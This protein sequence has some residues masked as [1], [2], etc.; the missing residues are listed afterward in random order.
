MSDLGQLEQQLET[1]K[2]SLSRHEPRSAPSCGL[3]SA[4]PGRS[5]GSAGS[6]RQWPTVP[7]SREPVEPEAVE[8]PPDEIFLRPPSRDGLV[9]EPFGQSWTGWGSRLALVPQRPRV[10]TLFAL[11][12][13]CPRTERCDVLETA[14]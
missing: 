14:L 3:V 4:G 7:P 5:P 6:S 11:A 8:T 1:A 12:A 9:G 2:K 10:R 13:V